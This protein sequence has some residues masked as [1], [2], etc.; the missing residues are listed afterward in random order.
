MDMIQILPEQEREAQLK[1]Y[2]RVFAG[3][4]FELI[5]TFTF[6]GMETHALLNYRPLGD[7][8]NKITGAVVYAKDVTSRIVAER[9]VEKLVKESQNQIATLKLQEEKLHQNLEDLDQLKQNAE[10]IKFRADIYAQSILFVETDTKGRI[11]DVNDKLME[12]SGFKQKA[13][14]GKHYTMLIDMP[15]Q[16]LNVCSKNL[17]LGKTWKGVIKNKSK[18]GS[19]YWVDATIVPMSDSAGKVKKLFA[20]GYHIS[21]DRLGFE[22]YTEQARK[23]ETI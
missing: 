15:E 22:M 17:L 14:T 23:L 18:D 9:K 19:H 1:I 10:N 7:D 5:Q 8:H 3:E 13:L 12:V 21:N 16:L 6:E 11:L 2:S 20:T 4:D